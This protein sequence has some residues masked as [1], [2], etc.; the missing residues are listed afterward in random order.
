MYEVLSPPLNPTAIGEPHLHTSFY[1]IYESGLTKGGDVTSLRSEPT[2]NLST[3]S[4]YNKLG[5]GVAFESVDGI[6]RAG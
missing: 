1:I 2:V 6:F 5:I 3:T 4:F